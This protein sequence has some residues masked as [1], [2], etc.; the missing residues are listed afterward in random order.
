MAEDFGEKTHDATPHR[1]DKARE[2]GQ[3]PKSQDLSSAAILLAA[4]LAL[5]MLGGGVTKFLSRLTVRQFTEHTVLYFDASDAFAHLRRLMWD[6]ASTLTPLLGFFLL[7]AV[8]VNLFQVGFL[9]LP[10]KLAPKWSN[11]SPM[12]GVKRLFSISNWVRLAFGVFKVAVVAGIGLW[13]LWNDWENVMGLAAIEVPQT[14]A[15]IGQTL[16]WVAAKIG[17]VLFILALIDYFYQRW[18]H[19]QDI[20]MTDQEVRE[21][22][23][24]LQ[25]DPQMIARRKTIQRQMALN[26]MSEA[27]PSADMVVTNP[28]EL[29]VALKY[30]IEKDPAP[31]VVAKGAGV[32][33]QRIRRLALEHNVPIVERKPLAQFLYKEVEIGQPIPTEQ[34]AAVAELLRYVY[35]LQGKPLPSLDAA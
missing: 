19:E 25:G 10:E 3:I 23:K 31:I 21:E 26:R 22:M 12:Q 2:Q 34:F 35:Q 27:V 28:T 17:A 24:N 6:L 32:V 18:K 1:R 4:V 16:F 5:A 7:A 8:V 30:D 14:A 11:A 9:F 20:R 33:A 29:A 13:S 15:F